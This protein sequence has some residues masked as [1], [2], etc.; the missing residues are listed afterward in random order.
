M[1]DALS[2]SRADV[3][4]PNVSAVKFDKWYTSMANHVQ[5]NAKVYHTFLNIL[6]N[7]GTVVQFTMQ[8][9]QKYDSLIF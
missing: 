2:R 9:S 1:A 4:V 6:I 3:A 8:D 5:T 7:F